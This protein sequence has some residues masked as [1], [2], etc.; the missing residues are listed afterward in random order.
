MPIVVVAAVMALQVPSGVKTC[1]DG[2]VVLTTD[3]CIEYPDHRVVLTHR[4]EV[5]TTIVEW[6]CR[7][8]RGV[9]R[10]EMR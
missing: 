6:R 7:K 1:S 2:S 3:R 5:A 4:P 10:V 8:G 9:T